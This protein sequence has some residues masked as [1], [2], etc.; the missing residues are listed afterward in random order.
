MKE[1]IKKFE[2]PVMICSRFSATA[3]TVIAAV[4]YMYLALKKYFTSLLINF[5]F[6]MITFLFIDKGN[7]I[8][9]QLKLFGDLYYLCTDS[10]TIVKFY[11]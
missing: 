10:Q 4:L 7:F 8:I 3:S 6:S 5:F 2:W 9:T 1:L 11:I